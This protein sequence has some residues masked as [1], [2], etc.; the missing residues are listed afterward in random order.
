M[1]VQEV[2]KDG[3]PRSEFKDLHAKSHCSRY[4]WLDLKELLC[5]K[6]LRAVTLDRIQKNCMQQVI[7]D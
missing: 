1:S 4:P 3:Y 2:T 7:G 6:S 5:N